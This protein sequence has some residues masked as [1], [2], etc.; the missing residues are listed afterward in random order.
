MSVRLSANPFVLVDTDRLCPR[1]PCMLHKALRFRNNGRVKD[2]LVK[3]SYAGT[4]LRLPNR[5]CPQH[6][7]SLNGSLQ[8]IPLM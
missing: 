3:V 7:H 4:R 6:M 1:N 5:L 8:Y 2:K